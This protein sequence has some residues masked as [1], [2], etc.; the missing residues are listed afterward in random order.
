MSEKLKIAVCQY[1][2]IWNDPIANFSLIEELTSGLDYDI[3]VLPEMFSSGY[4]TNPTELNDPLAIKSKKW[5]EMQSSNALILGSCAN[6]EGEYFYNSLFGYHQQKQLCN[7]KK[8][9]TFVGGERET[10]TKGKETVILDHKE[11][12]I[13]TNICYDLRFPVWC[14]NQQSEVMV[15]SANWPTKR[16]DH[17]YTLLKARAIENQCYVVGVNRIGIDGNEWEYGGETV[18][19][20]HKGEEILNLK[21]TEAAQVI[22]IKKSDLTEYRTDLP[23]LEDRDNFTFE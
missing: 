11:W 2:V 13:S 3:L 10:Y 16:A 5:M 14:R 8:V 7:Y 6:K 4:F 21:G 18:I 9:H 19:F 23:F 1:N 15:F 20:N 12:K 22:E 17:W